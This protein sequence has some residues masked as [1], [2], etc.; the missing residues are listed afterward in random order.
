M[1]EPLALASEKQGVFPH[2]Q[3]EEQLGP[4]RSG[5]LAAAQKGTEA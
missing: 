1:Q 3:G 5:Q 4:Y 2:K